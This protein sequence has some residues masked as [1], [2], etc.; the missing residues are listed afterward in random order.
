MA[1]VCAASQAASD[2]APL[3]L[4]NTAISPDGNTIAF[5]FRGD[6]YTVPYTGGQATRLTTVDAYDSSPV[7]S[8][9]GKQIAFSSNRNGSTDIF[10]VDANGG[11][12]RR[13]TTHSGS[14]TPL[15]F[16]GDKII[17]TGNIMP[18][19]KAINGYVF[20]Q[21]YTVPVS[22]GRPELLLS[23]PAISLSVDNN[24]RILYTDKK[25]YED[26]F[27]KHE[28][29][30]GTSDVWLV[31]GALS[32]KTV[33]RQLTHTP[34]HS[35]NPQWG[36]GNSFYY[37]SEADSTL[38]VYAASLDGTT[39][40]QLTHFTKHPVRTLSVAQNGNMTF[41]Q[42]GEIYT[43]TAGS[44]PVKL[45][46][47]IVADNG[48]QTEKP[49]AYTRTSRMALAP[50]GDE[51]LLWCAATS[52]PLP[53]TIPPRAAS[54]PLPDR[55]A[56]SASAPTAASW[57][58]TPNATAAGSSTRLKLARRTPRS[59]TPR[60]SPRRRSTPAKATLSSPSSAPTA[61]RWLSCAT[62][63]RS[64]SSTCNQARQR[65]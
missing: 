26:K 38:N 57:S 46:V 65:W 24:G 34:Y 2:G 55:N 37:V 36:G 7:W 25:G 28:Q 43:M 27:R 13:L 20:P 64:V 62:A 58:M 61:R 42:N 5:T 31:E 39:P 1:M 22:G 9:D 18:S 35:V 45:P 40:R 15:A 14:E 56:P 48:E 30:S 32:G 17:F 60:L 33:F 19:Q 11:Q 29:S 49:V 63:P 3:W 12:P 51:V 6:I 41:S 21:L 44:E 8:P 50:A 4:R 59:L 10:I 52:S 47:T 23:L 54:P 16:A 53:P